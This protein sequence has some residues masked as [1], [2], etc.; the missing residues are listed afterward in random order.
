MLD[1]KLVNL[2]SMFVLIC[3]MLIMKSCV[4]IAKADNNINIKLP[5]IT[6]SNC[7]DYTDIA[8]RP[9][10]GKFGSGNKITSEDIDIMYNCNNNNIHKKTIDL[11]LCAKTYLSIHGP[12]D[13][14][15]CKLY[16]NLYNTMFCQTKV[17]KKL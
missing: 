10:M 17:N 16:S 5:T 7:Y 12:L 6:Y 13:E 9:L 1:T 8:C 11:E 2:I 3:L 15:V 14:Y 4:V